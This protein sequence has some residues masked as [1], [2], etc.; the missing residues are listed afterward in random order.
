M[1]ENTFD[2][3]ENANKFNNNNSG[4]GC[5]CATIIIGLCILATCG[6]AGIGQ[7]INVPYIGEATGIVLVVIVGA[8]FLPAIVAEVR[9]AEGAFAIF[10]LNLLLGWTLLGWLV[11]FVLAL[12]SRRRR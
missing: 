7:E 1:E 8:Y 9:K 6:L 5:G 11:A 2:N 12:C 10:L 4:C 3:S